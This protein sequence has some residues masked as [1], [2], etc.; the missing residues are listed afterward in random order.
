MLRSIPRNDLISGL[1]V[2]AIGAFAFVE[3]LNYPLGST[4]NMGPGYFP[5][6]LSTL[7]V[8]FGLG[9][10]FVEGR[11]SQSEEAGTEA[12]VAGVPL[13]PILANM[14]AFTS[15]AL[16]VEG[17]GLFVAALAAVFLAGLAN[18]ETSI[19]KAAIIAVVVSA[20]CC[21]VFVYGLRLQMRIFP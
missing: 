17:A 5:I 15:F 9:I 7:M 6:M 18:K 11:R 8:L 2:I 1:V 20:L 4:R 13:R 14:A 10:I 12:V 19:P 21:L 16:L 3:A